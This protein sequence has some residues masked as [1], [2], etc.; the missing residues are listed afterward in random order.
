[1]LVQPVFCRPLIERRQEL[2]LLHER[3]RSASAGRGGLV[4]VAG[5]AG[6]GKSRLLAEFVRS[7]A[8]PRL[9][10]ALAN[11]RE[12]AQRPY[13]PVLDVLE[14]LDAQT[15][16]LAPARSRDEQFE[17]LIRAFARE[18]ERSAIVAVVEDLHWSD[19]ASAELL[20]AIADAAKGQRL[21]LLAS[22]R[23]EAIGE[24]GAMFA[25]LAKLQRGAVTLRLRPLDDDAT[26]RFVDATLEATGDLPA[27]TRESIVHLSDG[28]PL[29]VEELR[30][31][32][33]GKNARRADRGRAAG[34]DSGG[35]PGAFTAALRR[36]APYPR[37]CCRRRA[38]F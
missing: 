15:G 17:P 3:R 33:A 31:E 9:R 23:P 21:L 16:A 10:V 34:D 30:K 13:A 19:P 37:A 8:V 25:S 28:N 5:E 35:D 29:F 7:L 36:G 32:R 11:C 14:Q 20:A 26:R 6:V 12:F 22:Y 27:R 18:A 38:P 2:E 4:L 24:D 1:M